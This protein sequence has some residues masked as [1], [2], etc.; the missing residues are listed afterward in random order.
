[1]KIQQTKK[2]IFFFFFVYFLT[3][4]APYVKP[5]QPAHKELI[6]IDKSIQIGQT[7][8]SR[9]D[10][11]QG[12]SIY[13][14]PNLQYNGELR[15]YLFDHP[16]DAVPLR[17][18]S[19]SLAEFNEPGFYNFNF[20]AISDS[21]GKDYYLS[22]VVNDPGSISVGVAPGNAYLNGA[23][24]IDN[25]PQNSQLSFQ[26][27]HAPN[28]YLLGL[29]NEGM[30]W[31]G[32]LAA[33]LFLL[34]I[35]GWAALSWLFP[36]W[37]SMNWIGKLT[38]ATGVGFAFYPLLFLWTDALGLHLGAMYAWLLPLIGLILIGSQILRDRREHI[39]RSSS[40]IEYQDDVNQ[41]SRKDWRLVVK[42][43]LPDLAFLLVMGTIVF[44]R[45][46]PIRTLD[47]PMWGDS[48]QHTTIAQLFVDNSGLFKSWQPYAE[49]LSFTYHFGF[50]SFV[51]AYH[52]LS[53]KELTQATLWMG[54]TLN[55]I[56]IM[57]L[58]PLALKVGKNRWAGV[59][60]VL[61]TGLV[62][63]M[64]MYYVNWGRY[65]QLAGQI[66]LPAAII[67]IWMNLESKPIN[68]K[69][70][71]LIWMVVSGLA[72]THY[73]V[74]IFLPL[75]Y[76]SFLIL[77]FRDIGEF[78]IV[79]RTLNH[80]MGA[81]VL[82]LPWAIRIFE[83]KLPSI[84]SDQVAIPAGQVSQTIQELNTI[85]N[86]PG[87]LPVFV[88]VLMFVSVIWGIIQRSKN[89]Y[90]VSLWWLLILL[91]ANPQWFGLPG[92]GV[93]SNFAVLIAVYI[94]AGVLIGSAVGDLIPGYNLGNLNSFRDPVRPGINEEP[95]YGHKREFLSIG[96]VF[97]LITSLSLWNIRIRIQD[98]QPGVHALVTRP[99]V[100]A[101][102]W[103]REHLPRNTKF[104]VNS[105]F[106]YGD[107]LVVGSDA[108][109]WLPLLASRETTLPPINYAFESGP[110]HNYVAFIN[111]L[112][113]EI[114][115]KG[116]SHPDIL[117][118]L[119]NRDVTHIY[120]GQQQGKVNTN[121]PPLL[122]VKDLLKDPNF[123][124]VYNQDLV[125]IFEIVNPEG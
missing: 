87:Y 73:R 29:A 34:A 10:G 50:H 28:H 44:T 82:I 106:A 47:A 22:L 69:W 123:R 57:A 70:N 81:L 24:Y 88:W 39:S 98:V 79:K 19:L 38:L 94:P 11:L 26:I 118:E 121:T 122:K 101:G 71:I 6:H 16:E 59:F 42:N 107:S 124:L 95:R 41:P 91:A 74:L 61:I 58:Y 125:K 1:M 83:G 55:I 105:F 97:L 13:F 4:C 108:G 117:G 72:L 52:W 49:L 60:A 3:A 68:W 23:L 89:Y 120:I 48:Y 37:R 96:F 85:G 40:T 32:V 67:I 110:S 7:F 43:V 93:L 66:M 15:F 102:A 31:L 62:S 90:V 27:E 112:V 54:Q 20:D 36:P 65:T 9:Y 77:R 111:N 119:Q 53:G 45:F 46:W 100:N 78:N 56:A 92:E 17:S 21:A 80:A 35:P 64:P 30:E 115:E 51:A 75:F 104:L 113:A 103:I 109:W 114:E 84:Y 63:P 5:E 86:L 99:D 8:L 76:I 25:K 12:I 18:V 2:F 33:G 116:I 14:V